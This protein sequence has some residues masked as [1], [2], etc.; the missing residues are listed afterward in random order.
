[1]YQAVWSSAW[2][3]RWPCKLATIGLLTL[4]VWDLLGSIHVLQ[5]QSLVGDGAADEHLRNFMLDAEQAV[6]WRR[7]ATQRKWSS[8]ELNRRLRTLG[9]IQTM[10]SIRSSSM[11]MLQTR[12][13]LDIELVRITQSLEEL[14][15]SKRDMEASYKRVIESMMNHKKS[16]VLRLF[17]VDRCAICLEDTDTMLSCC[18]CSVHRECVDEWRIRQPLAATCP[19]RCDAKPVGGL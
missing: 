19:R 12:M 14:R 3:V 2:M 17:T 1:M 16:P 8:G 11:S 18:G 6:E 5:Y 13:R 7:D 15:A 9:T 10:D 4:L